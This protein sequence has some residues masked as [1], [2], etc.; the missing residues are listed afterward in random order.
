MGEISDLGSALT[1]ERR[2]AGEG[3]S[4]RHKWGGWGSPGSA[5]PPLPALFFSLLI[6]EALL[7]E[8][9]STV[10][11]R[12]GAGWGGRPLRSPLRVPRSRPRLG[13]GAASA[14]TLG[15]DGGWAPRAGSDGGRG[16][17]GVGEAVGGLTV[18]TGFLR[19]GA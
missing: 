10:D 12:P 7:P 8:P 9:L 17:A 4:G 16:E 15:P 11:T 3:V 5:P 18:R 1:G 2:A 19:L 13:G 6:R 14:A